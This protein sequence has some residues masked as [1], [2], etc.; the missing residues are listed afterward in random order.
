V[1][2]YEFIARAKA[3]VVI[4]VIIYVVIWL[5]GALAFGYA[6]STWVLFNPLSWFWFAKVLHLMAAFLMGLAAFGDEEY[7]E[8]FL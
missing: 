5:I 7:F 2:S 8:T 3:A 4:F 6:L 1:K